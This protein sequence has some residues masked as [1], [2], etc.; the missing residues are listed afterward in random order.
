MSHRKT[1]C[2]LQTA[3][4]TNTSRKTGMQTRMLHCLVFF[5][6]PHFI[7]LFIEIA[8]QIKLGFTIF[9]AWICLI[10]VHNLCKRG[11]LPFIAP[12][13]CKD[14]SENKIISHIRVQE[15]EWKY[16]PLELVVAVHYIIHMFCKL[17][18]S[19]INNQSL[20]IPISTLLMLST[21]AHFPGT[22]LVA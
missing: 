15:I 4:I 22:K 8:A 19:H 11:Y 17:K 12:W 7:C 1:D 5:Q 16:N 2:E 14:K 20:S 10:L 21:E 6:P 13:I 18:W 9:V 3:D